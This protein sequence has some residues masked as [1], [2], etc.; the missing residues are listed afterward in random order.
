MRSRKEAAG[1]RQKTAREI[2]T[3]KVTKGTKK[4]NKTVFKFFVIF[5]Y[6]VVKYQMVGTERRGC[7][8]KYQG[9]PRWKRKRFS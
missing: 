2:R 7:P 3:T 1:T 9:V 8:K 4:K 6:F 5:V